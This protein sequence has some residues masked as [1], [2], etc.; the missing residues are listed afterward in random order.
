MFETEN[1]NLGIREFFAV[2]IFSIAMECTETTSV[3]FIRQGGTGAWIMPIVSYLTMLVPFLI[4]QSILKENKDKGL[5]DIINICTGKYVGFL[6][7]NILFIMILCS[8]ITTSRSYVDILNTMYF[9]RT[10]T[11]AI[12]LGLIGLSCYGAIKGF[13]IIGRACFIALPYIIVVMIILVISIW[14]ALDY[15]LTLP[16]GGTGMLPVLKGGIQYSSILG[17][18]VVLSIYFTSVK[19][20]TKYKIAS[21][22]GLIIS[23]L[24]LIFFKFAFLAVFSF[25]YLKIMNYPFH[26]LIRVSRLG[27][28]IQNIEAFFLGFWL[29]GV[30]LHLSIYF[31]AL[32][33]VFSV[34]YKIKNSKIFL[35]LFAILVIFIGRKIN[36]EIQLIFYY[37]SIQLKISSYII[38]A[39]PAILLTAFKLKGGG[40]K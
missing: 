25:P 17:S 33:S 20:F 8:I 29:I 36:N 12:Y 18:S 5:M 34:T 31:C 35:I 6:F 28:A 15:R 22:M 24:V 23:V 1:K 39:L 9:P 14:K 27:T 7:N 21:N 2:F 13:N 16:I 32:D 26:E 11:T 4:I 40:S 30:V 19:D 37:R 38:L 10:P 3:I